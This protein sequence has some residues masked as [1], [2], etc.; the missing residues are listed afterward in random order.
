[1]MNK[2]FVLTILLAVLGMINGL[3]QEYLTGFNG[4]VSDQQTNESRDEIVATLPFFDDFTKSGLYPDEK[5]EEVY[6]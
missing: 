1:M 2:R 5:I 3:A 4:V 6:A